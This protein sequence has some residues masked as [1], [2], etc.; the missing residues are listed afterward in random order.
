MTRVATLVPSNQEEH[1]EQVDFGR[2]AD[3]RLYQRVLSVAT[4]QERRLA[5]HGAL[6]RSP[7]YDLSDPFIDDARSHVLPFGAPCQLVGDSEVVAFCGVDPMFPELWRVKR[8]H[9]QVLSCRRELVLPLPAQA[10]QQGDWALAVD[11]DAER[12]TLHGRRGFC[13]IQGGRGHG[14]GFWVSFEPDEPCFPPDI[15]FVEARHLVTIPVARGLPQTPWEAKY[16]SLQDEG[17]PELVDEAAVEA[18]LAVTRPEATESSDTCGSISCTETD[19]DTECTVPSRPKSDVKREASNTLLTCA[20][21]SNSA[22]HECPE[23]ESVMTVG[24]E[25]TGGFAVVVVDQAVEKS[26][27]CVVDDAQLELLRSLS[28]SILADVE[29]RFS[30][31]SSSSTPCKVPRGKRRRIFSASRRICDDD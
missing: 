17:D 5:L 1:L 8:L 18:R 25:E 19:D 23:P 24:H 3:S 6:R 16:S 28:P 7:G 22:D 30:P 21:K 2:D 10:A 4:S 27:V 31:S 29:E 12:D 11:L 20:T 14:H 15:V 26:K 13:G 9:G